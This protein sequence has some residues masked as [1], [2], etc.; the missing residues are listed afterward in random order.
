MVSLV[1]P[2]RTDLLATTRR[3]VGGVFHGHELGVTDLRDD[4]GQPLH[5]VVGVGEDCVGQGE[6]AVEFDLPAG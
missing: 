2:E 4:H 5:A 3:H 1:A 6:G